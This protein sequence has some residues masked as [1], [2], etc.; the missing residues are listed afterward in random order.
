M[1]VRVIK[2]ML[3][4]GEEE[5]LI[6]DLFDEDM[7]VDDFKKLY[8]MRWPVETKYDELKNKLEIENFTGWTKKAIEQDF[9]ATMYLSNIAAAARWEAQGIVD[10]ERIGKNIAA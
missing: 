3:G 7:G 4:S 5:M 1:K 8:F 2:F 9:Y 10:N 6:T